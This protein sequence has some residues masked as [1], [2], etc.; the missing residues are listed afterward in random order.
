M[1]ENQGGL[2]NRITRQIY[3]RPFTLHECREYLEAHGMEWPMEEILRCYMVFGGVPFYWSLLDA[4]LS[5]AQ[6]LDALLFQRSGVLRG[7][8]DELY[9]RHGTARRRTGMDEDREP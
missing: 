9:G 4:H 1:L 2:H 8:F 6:N 5:L 3:L 7:E